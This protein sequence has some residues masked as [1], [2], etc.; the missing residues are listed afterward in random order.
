MMLQLGNPIDVGDCVFKQFWPIGFSNMFYVR[1]TVLSSPPWNT[2]KDSQFQS[3]PKEIGIKTTVPLIQFPIILNSMQKQMLNLWLNP[4]FWIPNQNPECIILTILGKS[5]LFAKYLWVA[6]SWT[7]IL[8]K[9]SALGPIQAHRV[10]LHTAAW[11]DLC[12]CL[13]T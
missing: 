7:L 11:L 13:C 12:D 4:V 5:W 9:Y 2:A 1:E 8:Q 3:G 10:G 6:I